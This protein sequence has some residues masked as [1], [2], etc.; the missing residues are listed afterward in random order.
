MKK[1]FLICTLLLSI[2]TLATSYVDIPIFWANTYYMS[3]TGSDSNPGTIASPFKTLTKLTSV[4]SA[5][6]IGY[7]R[8]GTYQSTAGNGASTHFQINNLTG[9]SGANIYILAYPG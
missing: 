5:G 6:D 2:K 1:I 8:G 4:L 3:P 7:V 9:T